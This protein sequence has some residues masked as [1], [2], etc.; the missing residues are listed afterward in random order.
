MDNGCP[1][2]RKP[3][4]AKANDYKRSNIVVPTIE[5]AKM[6]ITN[7]TIGEEYAACRAKPDST[8][9]TKKVFEFGQTVT[10]QCGLIL[11][12]KP[13]GNSTIVQK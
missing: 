11:D 4:P 6:E 7:S 9:W 10:L 3:D 12:L 1:T 5:K 2:A 8:S 13:Y